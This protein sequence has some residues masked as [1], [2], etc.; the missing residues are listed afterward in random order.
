MVLHG[1]TSIVGVARGRGGGLMLRR[2]VDGGGGGRRVLGRLLLLL[3]LLCNNLLQLLQL[4][5]LILQRLCVPRVCLQRRG[6]RCGPLWLRT[7]AT[8]AIRGHGG[9]VA[10]S[11]I[12]W[13]HISLRIIKGPIGSIRCSIRCII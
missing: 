5:L 2:R 11:P 12:R 9:K 7:A 6:C 3:L 4:R 10:A 13:V 8:R 1:V